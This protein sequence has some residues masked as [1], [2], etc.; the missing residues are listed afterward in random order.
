VHPKFDTGA[1]LWPPLSPDIHKDMFKND[2]RRQ[3]HSNYACMKPDAIVTRQKRFAHRESQGQVKE[4]QAR[5]DEDGLR[6]EQQEP[7]A[8]DGSEAEGEEA[9]VSKSLAELGFEFGLDVLFTAGLV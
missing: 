5:V 3:C 7:E 6:L 8:A 4:G 9:G 1:A 2:T